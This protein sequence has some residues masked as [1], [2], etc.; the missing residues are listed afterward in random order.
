MESAREA[1]V[2]GIDRDWLVA[3]AEIDPIAHAF[4]LWD[5]DHEPDHVRFVSLRRGDQTVGY[6]L[7]WYG[8]DVPIVHWVS[9]DPSDAMLGLGLPWP[10][11]IAL[12]PERV[13]EAVAAKLHTT[14]TEPLDL[15]ACE[16]RTLG[17]PDPRVRRLRTADTPALGE[18]IA[19][20]PGAEMAGY[21]QADLERSPVWGAFEANRLVAV[22]RIQVQ[23]PS[24]WII[25][26]VFTDPAF[27]GRGLGREVTAAATAQALATGARAALYVRADNAAAQ[28]IYREV[29][30]ARV[31]RRIRVDASGTGAH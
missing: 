25:G 27:R 16:G 15:L 30:Y 12:V 6:L 28:T 1:L 19:R 9:R 11:V 23:L 17:S 22:A 14:Q 18:M 2:E 13:A 26:G 8:G 21:A 24:V 10:P 31:E 5:I 7:A 20:N 29:G 3:Q 4:A